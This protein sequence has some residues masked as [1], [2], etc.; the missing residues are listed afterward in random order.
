MPRKIRSLAFESEDL[1]SIPIE[2]RS[3]AKGFHEF[4]TATQQV[5]RWL[6]TCTLTQDIHSF[7][8]KFECAVADAKRQL[9]R[10]MGREAFE[11]IDERMQIEG[12]SL[13]NFLQSGPAFSTPA[14]ESEEHERLFSAVDE[15]HEHLI[16][17]AKE[18]AFSLAGYLLKAK[19]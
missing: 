15:L 3:F 14:H 7:M 13:E 19:F 8:D 6:G 1:K 5:R 12:I 10:A 4:S 18:P 16:G 9:Q 11:G 17:L 2:V